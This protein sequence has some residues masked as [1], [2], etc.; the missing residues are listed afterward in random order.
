MYVLV[1]LQEISDGKVD[2]SLRVRTLKSSNTLW[3]RVAFK[4]L[5][6]GIWEGEVARRTQKLIAVQLEFELCP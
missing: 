5:F 4:I 2:K 3:L 6:C 1:A